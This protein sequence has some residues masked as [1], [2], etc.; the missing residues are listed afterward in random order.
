MINGFIHLS[1]GLS[2]AYPIATPEGR[3]VSNSG[4][5]FSIA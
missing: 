5:G 2:N 4:M 3:F 1:D